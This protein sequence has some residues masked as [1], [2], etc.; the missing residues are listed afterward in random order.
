MQKN[1]DVKYRIV[2]LHYIYIYVYVY[3]LFTRLRL[4][5]KVKRDFALVRGSKI[6]KK[7]HDVTYWIVAL[8]YIYIYIFVHKV[9]AIAK[10]NRVSCVVVP[11]V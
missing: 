5:L 7:I 1:Q 10:F 6:A 4:Y 11:F 8:H 9:K 2:A 3:I